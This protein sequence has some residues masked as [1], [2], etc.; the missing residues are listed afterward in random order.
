MMLDQAALDGT[1]FYQGI[2]NYRR[3]RDRPMLLAFQRDAAQSSPLLRALLTGISGWT[4]WRLRRDMARA[5]A[6]SASK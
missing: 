4:N 1:L 5:F 6:A 2:I 3:D